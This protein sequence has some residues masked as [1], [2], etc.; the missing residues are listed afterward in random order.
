MQNSSSFLIGYDEK[1]LNFRVAFEVEPRNIMK[2][3]SSA[4]IIFKDYK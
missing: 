1:G 2:E 4:L 3:L